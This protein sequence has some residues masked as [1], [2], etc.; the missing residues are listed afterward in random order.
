M[1]YA[2]PQEHVPEAERNNCAIKECFRAAFHRLPFKKLPKNM[3]KILRMESA[4]KLNFFPPKGGISPYYSPRMIL[5]QQSLDY[6]K[7]C[8]IPFGSYV[9][10]HH[11]P[12]HKNNQQP[13]TLDCI[14]LRYV[15]NDQGGHNLLDLRTGRTIKRRTVT[16]IPITQNVIDLVH[17]MAENDNMKDGLKIETKSGI[18]LY[19][20]SW[21]AGVDYE[22]YNENDDITIEDHENMENEENV[23][24][25]E[26]DNNYD[27]HDEMNP[28][29]ILDA[30]HLDL[31][32][33]RA[34]V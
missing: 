11:E 6:V 15:D 21:I 8:S 24:N 2:N 22:N 17:K 33:G 9:Q 26:N 1:N 23:E 31:E 29:E 12:D 4:K 3:V 25:V 7:H 18:I 14:Y 5:H 30:T 34:H 28:N 16:T 13:R 20:S 27:D 19:D 32:I 10:A